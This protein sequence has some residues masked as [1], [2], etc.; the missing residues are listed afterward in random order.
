MLK[1][2]RSDRAKVGSSQGRPGFDHMTAFV[3]FMVEFWRECASFH[4]ST[5]V[6]TVTHSTLVQASTF[7]E[8]TSNSAAA[9]EMLRR[10][11]K[12]N[13]RNRVNK[14]HAPRLIHSQPNSVHAIH[15]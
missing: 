13:V 9:Q 14:R 6:S 2:Y 15:I 8:G 12:P 5:Q 7:S 3:E 10:L 11:R 4:S 1:S